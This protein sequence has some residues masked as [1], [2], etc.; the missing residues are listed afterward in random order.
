MSG[1]NMFV[2]YTSADGNNVTVSPRSSGGYD[3]PTFNG[4][5]QVELLEGSGVSNGIMTA[6]VK[7]KFLVL[8]ALTHA[9]D[10]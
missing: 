4:N 6:N 8:Q 5:T 10:L 9:D 3:M 7:C 1:S 2:V